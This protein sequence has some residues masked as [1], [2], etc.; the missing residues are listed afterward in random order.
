MGEAK[1]AKVEELCRQYGVRQETTTG[2]SP[3][4]NAF[5]ERWPRTNAEMSRCQMLQ[6]DTDETY[7]EDSR[8]MATFIYNRV[9]PARKI[10]GE[11]W[12]TPLKKQYPERRSM[13]MQRSDR[14][15]LYAMCTRISQY[16]TKAFMGRVIRRRTL[17]RAY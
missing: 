2:Y 10:P 14:L 12:T 7:W 15:V 1:S 6:Y 17:R 5:V 13:D 16:V 4:H 3:A 9:P 11:P 8:R